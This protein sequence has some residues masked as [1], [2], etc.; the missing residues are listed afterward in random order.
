MPKGYWIAHVDVHDPE[1]YQSYREANAVA[2]EKFGARFL[3]RGGAQQVREGEARPRSVVIEFKD[4]ETAIAC[5][6][7]P[8][9][10]A[11][12]AFRDPA[13]TGDLMIVEGYDG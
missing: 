9:Y 6:E 5:Y 2:F 7:S 11:A 1:A 13:S 4:L 12:K 8:E 10:K 3:I